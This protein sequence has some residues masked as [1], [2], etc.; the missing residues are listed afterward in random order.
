MYHLLSHL[1]GVERESRKTVVV[2]ETK[3]EVN[4]EKVYVWSGMDVE[5]F[6]VIHVDVSRGHSSLDAFLFLRELPKRCLGKPLV[7]VGR[8]WYDWALETL[9]CDYEKETFGERSL[10]HG[11][12]SSS[13]ELFWHR[14]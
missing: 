12:V 8:R 2:A 7:K 9:G 14:R 4:G 1:F 3:L 5:T 11:S 13:T 6:E 10:R